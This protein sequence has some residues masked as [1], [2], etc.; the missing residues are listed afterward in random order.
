M[1]VFRLGHQRDLTEEDLT[2]PLREH[3]S[4]FLGDRLSRLWSTEVDRAEGYGELPSLTK[5]L[6]KCFAYEL[7]VYGAVLSVMEVGLRLSQPFFLGLLL[8]YFHPD[9]A[10]NQLP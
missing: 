6:F 7:L 1:K 4:S 5:V 10:K 2:Q 8:R 9:N 3:K